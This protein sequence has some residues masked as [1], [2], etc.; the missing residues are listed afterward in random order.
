MNYGLELVRAGRPQEGLRRYA[1]AYAHALALPE[2]QVTPELREALLT[3]YTA[4]LSAA[5]D[6]AGVVRTLESPLAQRGRLSASLH[7]TRGLALMELERF[8]EAIGDFRRCLATRG[9]PTVTPA[10]SDILKGGPHHCLALVLARTGDAQAAAQA[11]QEA[12]AADPQSRPVSID[13]AVFLA[14]HS[15]PVEALRVLHGLVGAHSQDPA[16]WILGGRIALSRPEFR[17]FAQDWTGEALKY[18]PQEPWVVLQRAEALLLAQDVDGALALWQRLSAPMPPRAWAG[19]ILCECLRGLP[20]TV[21]P[22]AEPAVSQELLGWYRRFLDWEA[23]DLVRAV[24]D[25]VPRLQQLLP[26]ATRVLEQA[27]LEA[28]RQNAG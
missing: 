10:R 18:L 26:T 13:W 3:Q 12:L 16:V 4:Q 15:Q 11:F 20:S 22:N 25:H 14:E 21:P 5:K 17:E 24:N 1:E 2:A 9:E 8:D 23:G 7:F 28:D 6:W 19:R 27:L